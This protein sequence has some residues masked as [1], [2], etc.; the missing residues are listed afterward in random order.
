MSK[1]W[2]PLTDIPDLTGKVAVVTG[3]NS[4]I[5]LAIIKFLATRGA[6]VYYTTRSE[7]K[8]Q[9][10]LEELLSKSPDINPDN[11]KWLTMD[12]TDLKSIVTAAE[13]LQKQES[14]VDILLNNAAASTAE[15]D[16]IG[17]GW[18]VHMAVNFV[19]P[20]VFTN[21]ILPLLKN[22]QSK[23]DADVRIVSVS[24]AAQ[25]AMLPKGFKFQFDTPT[26]LSKPVSYYP[27]MWRCLLKHMFGF[28]MIRY[29]VSKAATCMFAQELQR[30][31]D[32]S[33]IP[34]LSLAVHPG[35]IATEGVMRIN[36]ALV[37]L[38]ARLTFATPD[39]GAATPLFAAVATEVRDD[40]EKYKGKLIMPVGGIDNAHPSTQNKG[41]V[42]ALWEMTT[43]E[44][45]EELVAHNLLP[46]QAW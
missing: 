34:I 3:G 17:P 16:L 21:H 36:T 4:N 35:E 43:K 5:G 19:G 39:Q 29:A 6:R 22:A 11:I 37:G 41:Q 8:S 26:A 15:T 30:R 10:V 18:E 14:S 20:F 12:F 32:E 7:T 24:S 13:K 2:D 25:N 28:D 44:A 42:K 9:Q 23:I 31:L 38:I 46:L 1:T 40:P 33:G 27:W 45:N